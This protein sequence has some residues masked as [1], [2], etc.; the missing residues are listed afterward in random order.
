VLC[1]RST[2][3]GVEREL[4]LVE[5]GSTGIVLKEGRKG[6]GSLM[7]KRWTSNQI[8]KRRL[9]DQRESAFAEPERETVETS[10]RKHE[11]DIMFSCFQ[12]LLGSFLKGR[13]E[14]GGGGEWGE[15]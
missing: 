5:N 14:N 12:L 10:H 11:R 8:P 7:R 3:G 15:E 6:R 13:G 9:E 4:V 1:G 2:R